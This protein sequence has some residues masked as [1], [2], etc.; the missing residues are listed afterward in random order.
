MS[1]L[2][3][4]KVLTRV[5]LF[6]AFGC[7][8]ACGKKEQS[9]SGNRLAN[10]SSP[11]LRE[12]ADNPVDWYEWG[13]E[14]LSKAQRE[15]KP[16]L[17]SIGYSSCHWCHVMEAETFMDT[18]VARMM[19]EN[20]VCIKIDREERPDIDQIFI[21]ASQL[22]SGNA[23][24]PLNAF[25]L[26]DGRPFFAAT[27]FPKQQWMQLLTQ[28]VRTYAD[29]ERSLRKQAGAIMQSVRAQD[30]WMPSMDSVA[31][32]TVSQTEIFDDWKPFFDV[33]LGGLSGAPKFPMPVIWE[34]MLQYF[35]TTKDSAALKL[36]L[37]TLDGMGSGG[38]YDHLAGGFARYATD[39]LWRIPHFEKMLYDNAQLVKL[40]AEAYQ[41]T[42]DPHYETIVRETLAFVKAKLT[43][44]DG[45]FYSSVNADSEGEEGAFY[46][47]SRNEINDAL[48]KEE[49][50]RFSATFN[51]T[52]EGNWEA[53][54]NVLFRS[55]GSVRRSTINSQDSH[56]KS[57]TNALEKSRKIL[58]EIRNR[59]VHP[60]TDDKIITSW[61]A[62]MI[63]GYVQA[64][65]AL[66]ND[67]YLDAARKAANVLEADRM[68]KD[69]HLFRTKANAHAPIDAFLDDYA[70]L[71]RAF[72][73]LYQSTFD[74]RYLK[75]AHL[76]ADYVITNFR[77]DQTGL[78]YYSLDKSAQQIARKIETADEV[79]ASS[80]A[81]F[82]EALYLL[83]EYYQDERYQRTSAHM[84][85]VMTPMLTGQGPFYA[86]WARLKGLHENNPYEVAIVGP[87]AA[88]KRNQLLKAYLPTVIVSG[89]DEENLPL[90]ENK[91]VAGKTLIYVCRNKVCKFPVE[92]VADAMQ[93]LKQ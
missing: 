82:A 62:L 44:D 19:N 65:A 76:L 58:F 3:K 71:C 64:F 66:G 54:K 11:Y 57:E 67:E 7:L 61:N 55:G 70:F 38:I 21:N 35:Y 59:R 4:I 72:I 2:L 92:H 9:A 29:D 85:N 45:L 15:G 91:K 87:D 83:G 89:G 6:V 73:K 36:T 33:R 56:N 43:N 27:Y 93:Q 46:V 42:N 26:P 25:A 22:I 16:L 10:S 77:D 41:V 40:Y 28:V 17:I 79:I 81:A 68:S 52:P 53:G 8:V 23:G 20:F 13:D 74:I 37:A 39:S 30:A 49:S 63:E 86:G 5:G 51:V 12:H 50:E 47:W 90:L 80:N 31:P 14:A 88:K 75:A 60:T 84:I 18:A 34:F 69:G 32:S 48:G 1:S 24:W 78:F